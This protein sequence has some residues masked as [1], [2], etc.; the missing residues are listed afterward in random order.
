M[1]I[2][3]SFDMGSIKRVAVVGFVPY[4]GEPDSGKSM[5]DAAINAL[6][7]QGY[8]VVEKE[9][10]REVLSSLKLKVSESYI[11]S[12]I[13]QIAKALSVDAVLFG[14]ILDYYI[15]GSSEGVVHD[16]TPQ[17]GPGAYIPY[18]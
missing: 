1:E 16:S 14:K 17:P 8:E 9:K 4:P 2:E 15:S 18:A 7:R 13:T 5:E 3:P 11:P 6:K 10:V 12:E